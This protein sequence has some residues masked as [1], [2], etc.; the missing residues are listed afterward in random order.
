MPD[1]RIEGTVPEEAGMRNAPQEGRIS[2]LENRINTLSTGIEKEKRSAEEEKQKQK[3]EDKPIT[4]GGVQAAL[5]KLMKSIAMAL[6]RVSSSID[7]KIRDIGK[8]YA[9]QDQA[10]KFAEDAVPPMLR[11]LGTSGGANPSAGNV[12]MVQ[13]GG[14]GGQDSTYVGIIKGGVATTIEEVW[15]LGVKSIAGAVA[16]FYE[17]Y[18]MK[19]TQAAGSVAETELNITKQ[20]QIAYLSYS[21]TSG[22]ATLGL[23]DTFPLSGSNTYVKPL[24]SF[25]FSG[26]VASK[27]FTYH[28]GVVQI[29]SAYA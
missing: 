24:Q 5:D 25:N 22:A 8:I 14:K 1:K 26:G 2:A 11:G 27:L 21:L 15:A 3:P 16:T 4:F 28:K 10:K 18:T 17:G 29:D 23:S 12:I 6:N 7:G 20:G 13:P 19:G 9:T